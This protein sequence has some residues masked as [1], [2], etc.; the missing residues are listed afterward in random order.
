MK[1]TL[2]CL[3]LCD[4]MDYIVHGILQARILK[5]AAIS[6]DNDSLKQKFSVSNHM[7]QPY[8]GQRIIMFVYL[9]LD[10]PLFKV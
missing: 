5:W 4:P 10:K 3:T 2:S 6:L 7:D 1:V 9:G 8:C